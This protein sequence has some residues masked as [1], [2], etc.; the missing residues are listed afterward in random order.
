MNLLK[1]SLQDELDLFFKNY[2][3][4][5]VE[6]RIV[7]KAALCKAR[8]NLSHSTFIELNQH[9]I[10]QFYEKIEFKKWKGFRLSAIDGS[11]LKLPRNA[12][13][14]DHFGRQTGKEVPQARISL[15]YDVLNGL[16]IELFVK[17]IHDDERR[18]AH[19]HLENTSPNDLLL[20]DRGYPCFSLFSAHREFGSQFVMRLPTNFSRETTG[21]E[22]SSMRETEITL[23]ARR[24][25]T[26]QRCIRAQVSPAPMRIRLIKIRLPRGKIEILATSLLDKYLY[27][28]SDFKN[29]YALRWAIE[30]DYKTKKVWMEYENFSGKSVE[31]VYQ[32]IYAKL[33]IQN[34]AT[35]IGCAANPLLQ[36]RYKN[37]KFEYKI[38]KAQAISKMKHSFFKFMT[39]QAGKAIHSLIDLFVLTV[40]PIRSNRSFTRSKTFRQRHFYSQYRTVR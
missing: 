39:R 2:N 37:R 20:F 16:A 10:G 32:D 15:R 21:F 40:E 27:P 30:E 24:P 3:S 38:N 1:G 31:S 5:D 8:K 29:L 6:K 34:V 28:R 25:E 18:M 12:H 22:K 14:I 13:V 4:L 36:E 33:Y 26:R 35:L 7:S 9:L 23:K 17:S 11:T 19:Q